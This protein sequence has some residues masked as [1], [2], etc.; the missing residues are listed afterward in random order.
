MIIRKHSWWLPNSWDCEHLEQGAAWVHDAGLSEWVGPNFQ[1][2]DFHQVALEGH[3]LKELAP[4]MSSVLIP[5]FQLFANPKFS[6]QRLLMSKIRVAM[7]Q[8]GFWIFLDDLLSHLF[9]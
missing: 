1:I 6:S 8:K 4:G 5:I 3:L 7:E 2:Q 9:G